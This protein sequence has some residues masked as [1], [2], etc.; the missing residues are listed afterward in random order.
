M[1]VY[2]DIY[3]IENFIVNLFLLLISFR[4][5]H[6]EYKKRRIYLSA[7]IGAVYSI[8]L[9]YKDLSILVSLPF[10]ICVAFLM[11]IIAINS[12]S[13]KTIIKTTITYLLG[14]C[15]LAGVC[16][17]ASLFS[18]SYSIFKG[19]SIS[20]GS[21]KTIIIAALLLYIVITR[22]GEYLRDRTTVKNFMYDLEIPIEGNKLIVKAFLDTGNCLR[23]PVTNLPCII[24]E[25]NIFN[26]IN[27]N[28]AECFH[29]SY[30]TISDNGMMMGI[31]GN[32]I[33]ITNDGKEWR[34]LDAIL[35]GCPN[36]LS[37]DNEFNALLSRGII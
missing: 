9:F 25:K 17:G 8:L 26:M 2:I 35:C 37:E 10:K 1:V 22:I 19:Y 12:K 24:L 21:T 27:T 13:Y 32:K 5:L 20:N 31:K 30:N 15:T 36:K 33:R 23:E 7:L 18:N 14:S 34:T 11:I 4:L 3:L 6:F 28:D 16:F 29:I